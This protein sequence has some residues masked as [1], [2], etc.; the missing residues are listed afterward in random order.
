MSILTAFGFKQFAPLLPATHIIPHDLIVSHLEPFAARLDIEIINT[1][2]PVKANRTESMAY[3]EGGPQRYIHF[4]MNQRTL[5][6]HKSFPS[7][8][9]RDDGW[10]E[11]ETFITILEGT[12]E[13]SQYDYA[14]NGDYAATPYG[15]ITNGAP[16]S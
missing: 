8:M 10:C 2:Y 12:L 4:V 7:C 6:L 11:L 15:T 16:L 14:C 9:Y 13:E 3:E 1:P 5:P